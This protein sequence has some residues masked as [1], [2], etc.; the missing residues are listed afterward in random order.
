MFLSVN[1]KKVLIIDDDLSLQ[2][3]LCAR[4]EKREGVDVIQAANGQLG[5]PQSDDKNPD[6]IILDWMLPDIQGPDALQQLRKHKNTQDTPV[7]MLTGRN[8]MGDIEDA[9]YLGA[10]GYL[11][12]PFSLQ[13]LGKKVSKMLAKSQGR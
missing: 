7:L 12:K 9:F 11:T 1:K 5:L 10:D 3:Q 6:L 4:L 8:K 2:R 13:V